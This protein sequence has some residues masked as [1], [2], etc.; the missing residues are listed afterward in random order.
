MAARRSRKKRP[1]TTRVVLDAEKIT[2]LL[3]ELAGDLGEGAQPTVIGWRGRLGNLTRARADYPNGWTITINLAR[4]GVKVNGQGALTSWS[5]S[6][7]GTV[8][9]KV[10]A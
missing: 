8:K 9:G 4:T 2:P 6:W 7:C 5:A 3:I 10:A 1:S